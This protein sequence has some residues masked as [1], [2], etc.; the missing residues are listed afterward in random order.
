[1][2]FD[3]IVI[4]SGISGGWAAKEL[5]ERGL[6]TLLIERGPLI[7]HRIDYL[8]YLSPWELKTRGWVSED[9][10]REHYP[11][12]AWSY[13]FN[14]ATKHFWVKDSEHPY[15]TP[16]DRPFNWLRGYHLGGRSITWGRQTYRMSDVDFTANKLDGQGVDWPIRYAD[17]ARWYDHVERFAGISGAAENLPHLPDGE[18]L[19]PMELNCVE[20]EFKAQLEKRHPARR[21]TVGRCAHL[22][23]P[24]PDQIA[25]GR[26]PCQ[27]RNVCERGCSY[28]GY[29]SSLS[30]TLP[31]AERTGLLTTV[32]DAIV[33]RLE[34]DAETRRISAVRVVD[35]RTR[36]GRTYSARVVFLCASTIPTAQILLNSRSEHFPTGLANRSDAVGRYLMDHLHGMGATG[37]HREFADRYYYGRRP[38]GIYIPRYYNVTERESEAEFLRGYAFQGM[39][40]RPGWERAENLSGIGADFKKQL[41]LP[42]AW[43]L[44]LEAF[45]EMLPRA[46][47]R[48]TLNETRRDS[49][50]QPVL[51]IDCT[52][53][54]NDRKI[55]ARA[56]RDA[57]A[58][59][60]EAG[61]IDIKPNPNPLP[62]GTT[63]HEMGTARMG[64]DPAT[65]VLNGNNQAHDVP[66]LFIT[67]GSCMSS[68]ACV[69][70]SLTYMALTARA[71]NIAAD[72]VAER[73]L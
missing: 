6:K 39:G 32:T 18:F 21:V 36:E 52:H 28:G 58:M 70:P 15:E 5:C 63:V 16:P 43:Q 34:F 12:Q 22:T 31:A 24:L 44:R 65:S 14:T 55:S 37:T 62:P 3:A 7:R 61:F 23:A 68:S 20:S 66:N 54:E 64:L 10:K 42:G 45:G 1:M 2:D 13:A 9:E 48:V 26:G 60:E 33:E 47:N 71:A 11:V 35:A 73:T 67:D 29:F 40:F 8:D 38:T 41:R 49:W 4:G 46:D 57:M 50:G 30:A 53:G 51:R 17:L 72:L 59:L 56:Y 25:V 69:N 27:L 19:P